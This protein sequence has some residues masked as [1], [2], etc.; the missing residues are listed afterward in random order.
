M[1]IMKGK[2]IRFKDCFT[3]RI[4]KF[5]NKRSLNT[6]KYSRLNM[7]LMVLF[8]F[9]I[10]SMAEINQGKYISSYFSFLVNRPSVVLFDVMIA[11]CIY[12]FL[13]AIIKKGWIATFIQ[14]LVYMTLSIVELF[15]YGTNGNH[16]ILSDMRIATNV[17]SL[18]SFAY[19]KITPRLI[20]YCV[21]ALIYVGIVFYF[22]PK[23]KLRPLKRAV[24]SVACVIP[25]AALVF[26]PQFSETVYSLFS[27]DDVSATNTFILN[28]KFEN[29]S[30]LAFLV[31][32]ASES[33]NSRLTE[34]ENYTQ[35]KID[36]LFDVDVEQNHNFNNGKKPNVITIMSESYADFRAFDQLDVD[37]SYYEGFDKARSEGYAG[38]AI[39]PTYA[40][41]TVRS[42]FELI[43]GMPVKGIKDPNMPQR[44]LAER[45]VPSVANYYNDWGY[46]T[47]YIHPFQKSFYSRERVYPRFGFNKMIFHEAEESDFTVPVENFGT[48]VDD[49]TVFNQI[50]SLITESDKP[51]YVHTTTMQNHQ[52]YDQGDDPENE[53]GNYLQWIQH[54]NEGLTAFLEALKTIDE[55]T[56]VFFVG[57]HFPSLRGE[58]S[59]YNQLGLNG[60]NCGVLYEQAY[61]L[62]SNYDADFSAVPENN[63]SFFY[64]PYVLMNVI[65]APRDS[66]IQKMNNLMDEVPVYSTNY[67]SNI[68]EN[69]ELDLITYDRVIGD[70][71]SPSLITDDMLY[72]CIEED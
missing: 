44:E 70:L 48:Y 22:N 68:P 25:C 16:L 3:K 40:S 19:I 31:E 26:V 37:D 45:A 41:W 6:D 47:V 23:F 7:I 46:E 38:T 35:E 15:K 66:F 10:C 4:H 2:I 33:F 27:V 42:E 55:P 51:V 14:S 63:V 13:L 67:D 20:I 69:D 61:F 59:V 9:F 57:D 30:F 56:I 54:T 5:N 24:T 21:I 65:D 43:L 39:T 8:P 62:W 1:I 11:S 72:A 32:T 58:T 18:T 50:K 12:I 29:N 28:E 53:F 36:E 64:M 52:P 34:P 17:K 71:M 60:D 49:S